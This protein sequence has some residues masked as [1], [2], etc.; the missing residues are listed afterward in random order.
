MIQLYSFSDIISTNDGF[1]G[2]SS[3][4]ANPW[5][6]KF[7]FHFE[8]TWNKNKNKRK[9]FRKSLKI[10]RKSFIVEF[11]FRKVASLQFAVL[12]KNGSINDIFLA[13]SWNIQITICQNTPNYFW[14]IH[15]PIKLGSISYWW[16]FKQLPFA[17]HM[18]YILKQLIC[19]IKKILL[20][21]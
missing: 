10:F 11:F 12:H 19:M 20:D 8:L 2:T 14:V 21:I 13:N 9:L 3:L 6:I 18:T 7:C 4:S 15:I 17:V 16:H 5:V 1:L